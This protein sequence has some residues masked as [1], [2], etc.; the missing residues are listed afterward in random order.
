M[1]KETIQQ[2]A[3]EVV[4]RLPDT[5][6]GWYWFLG[7]QTVLMVLA[8]GAAA[9]FGSYLR[10]R[11]QNLATTHDFD[12]LKKQLKENTEAVEDIKSEFS[13]REWARREWANLRR[14]KLEALVKKAYECEVYLDRRRHDAMDGKGAS[15]ER[16]PIDEL[17]ALSTYFTE[18]T[19]EVGRY[20]IL[21][22]EQSMLVLELAS[23]MHAAQSA[24]DVSAVDVALANFNA[25]WTE[26]YPKSLNARRELVDAASPLLK[27]IMNVDERA[28]GAER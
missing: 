12:E 14:V 24:H 8:A 28:P 26:R 27:R 1:D 17:Y 23:A 5:G 10:T 18:L 25:K 4:A 19:N 7:F 15:G 22:R 16:D 6:Y 11:G 9:Y 2:I 21:C 20:A 13:Q 3:A